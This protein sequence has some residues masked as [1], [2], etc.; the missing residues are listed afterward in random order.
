MLL[1]AAL[2]AAI[3]PVQ[4]QQ[5]TPAIPAPSYPHTA[6]REEGSSQQPL[7][8]I[9]ELLIQVERNEE[10]AEAIQN[11]YTY[12]VHFEEQDLDSKGNIKKTEVTESE[13]LALNGV[14]VDR[15]VAR[16][17]RPLTPEEAKKE[18]QRIDKRIAKEK[19]ERAKREGSGAN[20]DIVLSAARI[21]ELGTFSNPRR[22][23]LDGRPTIVVDYA[24]DPNAKTRTRFE[25]VV[26]DLAGTAWVDEQDRVLVRAQGRFLR[27]FKVGGGL[28]ADIKSGS[29]FEA[30][31]AMV[32]REVWLPS[33]IAAQ[34]RIRILLVTGFNGRIQ[35]AM[36]DYKKF[37]TS[38]T[39]ESGRM[40]GPDGKPVVEQPV[41]TSAAPLSA[42]SD[43]Q[44]VTGAASKP[45]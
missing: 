25:S 24:G 35:M 31:Y 43:R 20:G 15:V 3:L 39:I 40:I 33:A 28:I 5:P 45:R 26:R 11:D 37:R 30:R 10:A 27:D 42:A 41:W 7:P 19:A 13:S 29:S 2:C 32:N 14:R 9:P 6:A 16:N 36:S 38:T 21:L 12:H 1:S 8:P 22:V 18:N 23:D 17:G 44:P 4:A 34:G